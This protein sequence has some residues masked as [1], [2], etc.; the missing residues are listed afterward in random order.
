MEE[1]VCIIFG[2]FVCFA[3]IIALIIA[4]CWYGA[5]NSRL[6]KEN[7]RL[8]RVLEDYYQ[9][10]QASLDAHIALSQETQQYMEGWPSR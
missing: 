10:E 9:L 8:R 4:V 1:I 6:Y 7:R 2:F 5:E 3:I